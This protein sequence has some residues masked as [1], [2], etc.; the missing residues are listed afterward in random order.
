MKISL[1]FADAIAHRQ[2][3]LDRDPMVRRSRDI[4]LDQAEAERDARAR[5]AEAE[6]RTDYKPRRHFGSKVIRE[7]A[8]QRDKERWASEK[9]AAGIRDYNFHE[10]EE[11]RLAAIRE[12]NRLASK[13]ARD[14]KAATAA[15]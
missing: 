8:K 3:A 14:R 10:T 12:S 1:H 5:Q 2:A 7:L 4:T 13:K 15:A 6:G 9:W 11:A